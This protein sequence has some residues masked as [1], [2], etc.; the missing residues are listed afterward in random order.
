[1]TVFHGFSYWLS[2]YT[3][4]ATAVKAWWIILGYQGAVVA[5][6]TVSAYACYLRSNKNVEMS[7]RSITGAVENCRKL[8][9]VLLVFCCAGLVLHA[10]SKLALVNF[11]LSNC[12]GELRNAWITTP[13]DQIPIFRRVTSILGHLLSSLTYVGL[14]FSIYQYSIGMRKTASI[15]FAC[16]F[17]LVG[18]GY[19][20]FIGSQNVVLAH[21]VII[22]LAIGLGATSAPVFWQG[23]GRSLAV[24]ICFAMLAGFFSASVF[25]NRVQCGGNVVAT[26][27]TFQYYEENFSDELPMKKKER[28]SGIT[29][30]VR[31]A[32]NT[33]NAIFI[34]LNHGIY[35]FQYIVAQGDLRGDP[36][37]FNFFRGIAKRLGFPIQENAKKLRVYGLGGATLP[38]SAYHDFGFGGLIYLGIAHVLMAIMA[39][40]LL[41]SGS[42]QWEGVGFVLFIIVGFVTALSLMFVGF[43]VI[44][45]PFVAWSAMVVAAVLIAWVKIRNYQIRQ[46]SDTGATVIMPGDFKIPMSVQDGQLNIDKISEK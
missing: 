26:T 37:F 6:L 45:F 36:V 17:F 32:C 38:G 31:Q 35:N 30:L 42:I 20:F 11:H 46:S 18:T 9:P 2:S 34:Y 28:A 41:R 16:I 22:A 40:R 8:L 4:S 23:W 1:V 7:A 10:Y 21:L 15:I 5:I 39:S 13:H 44:A 33:C 43:N 29:S 24:F 3:A 25:N 19:A 12:I 14:F 27:E